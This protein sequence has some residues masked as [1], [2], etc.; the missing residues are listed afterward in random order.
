MNRGKVQQ[1]AELNSSRLDLTRLWITNRCYKEWYQ[2]TELS[3]R[4]KAG[5]KSSQMLGK[6]FSDIMTSNYC[7]AVFPSQTLGNKLREKIVEM[8]HV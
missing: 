1:L 3:V 5:K 7:I 6:L 8:I 4:L 2:Q